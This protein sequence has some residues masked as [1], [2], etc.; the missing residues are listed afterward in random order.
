MSP[1][2]TAAF[3][4]DLD[5]A[6]VFSEIAALQDDRLFTSGDNLRVPSLNR[7]I[8]LAGGA[9]NAVAAR[10]RLR[11]AT[12]DKLT[13]PEIVP[14]NQATGDVEPGSPPA[15]MKMLEN[16]MSLGVDENLRAELNNNPGAVADQ[17]LIVWFADGPVTPLSGQEIFTL[18][19]TGTTTVTARAWSAVTLVLDEELPPGKYAIVGM[20]AE[21]A[22]CIAAR[23]INRE[24]DLWRPGCLGADDEVDLTD[25]VF[26]GGKLGI[27]ATFPFTQFP[28][29]EFLCDL[30]DTAEIVHFDLVKM[31]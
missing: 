27:W 11:S 17:W 28:D 21:S 20:R 25:P 24:G 19:G 14:L 16:P 7:I 23:V 1:I 12:L 15:I 2:H 10:L 8:M 3:L 13:L 9:D 30:A 26:R 31:S 22:S 29:V 5:S 6:G 4:E 18:R